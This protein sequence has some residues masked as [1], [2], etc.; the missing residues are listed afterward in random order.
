MALDLG[1][2]Q[3]V[4]RKTWST[5]AG[6]FIYSRE[7]ECFFC[8]DCFHIPAVLDDCKDLYTFHHSAPQWGIDSGQRQ[9]P[10]D[11]ARAAVRSQPPPIE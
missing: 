10:L 4:V 7:A 3:S 11:A 5:A 6:E 1:A 2:Q 9:A 8:K